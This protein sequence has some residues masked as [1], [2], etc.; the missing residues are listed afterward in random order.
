MAGTG[1]FQEADKIPIFL[2]DTLPAV[3]FL[4]RQELESFLFEEIS[5]FFPSHGEV[6]FAIFEILWEKSHYEKHSVAQYF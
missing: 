3:L 5:L 1:L 4:Y 6:P 2:I